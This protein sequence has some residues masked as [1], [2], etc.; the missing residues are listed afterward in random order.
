MPEK[1]KQ[2]TVSTHFSNV[3]SQLCGVMKQFIVDKF[4]E[5]YFKDIY[6]T[7]EDYSVRLGKR[8]DRQKHENLVRNK[9]PRLAIR[10]SYNVEESIL[11]GQNHDDWMQ[12]RFRQGHLDSAMLDKVYN[13]IYE[14]LF[15]DQYNISLYTL[16]KS[17][18]MTF[19]FSIAVESEMVL[20]DALNYVREE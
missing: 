3:I 12:K 15:M 18:K 10:P 2:I 19:D 1:F 7:T 4:P 6:M 16:P 8:N 20:Y 13:K 11:R 14:D 17:N 9:F 5:N